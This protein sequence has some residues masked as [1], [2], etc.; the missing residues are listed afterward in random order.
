[1]ARPDRVVR[2]HLRQRFLVTTKSGQAWSGL[3]VDA[4]ATTVL[5]ANVQSLAPDG[6][7]T[8]ADGQVFLPRADVAYMQLA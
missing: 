8:D 2:T 5:L 7:A 3:L 1:M 6:T 4:D